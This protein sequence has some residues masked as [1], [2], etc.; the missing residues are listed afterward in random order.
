MFAKVK[1][2]WAE[3]RK[4]VTNV[5]GAG[6]AWATLVTTSETGGITS[7]EWIAGAIL[8]ATAVGVYVAP[9]RSA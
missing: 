2:F 3:A 8:F 1:A 4:T 6:I 9:N 7:G 5:V